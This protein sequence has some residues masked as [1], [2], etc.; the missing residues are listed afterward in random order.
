LSKNQKKN[1]FYLQKRFKCIIFDAD[2]TM[3]VMMGKIETLKEMLA[4]GMVTCKQM[5]A[6]GIPTQLATCLVRQGHAVR[7][8]RGVYA[9]AESAFTEHSDLEVAAA[10]VPNGVICLVSALRFHNLTDENPHEV[11]MAIRHGYHPP[12]VTYPPIHFIVRSEPLFSSNVE[13]IK[14]NSATI[15]VYSLE[16]TI[17]DCFK[18]RNKIG[19]DIGLSAL[20]DAARQGRIDY[21]K[22]WA[23]ATGCR[24]SKII[25]PYAEVIL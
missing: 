23:A 2:L 1:R 3:E 5:R 17:A 13:N 8:A 15:R 24:V 9:S 7:L 14:L 6:L 19:L 22:L 10:L 11:S 12:K 25:R 16:Q 20:R 4:A 18:Y 21:N